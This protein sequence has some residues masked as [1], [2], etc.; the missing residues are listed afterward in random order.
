MLQKW[1]TK[2]LQELFPPLKQ[3][4]T[5]KNVRINFFRALESNS[6]LPTTK[7]NV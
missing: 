2:E 5:G 4:L 3:Q 1:W 7:G 6:K